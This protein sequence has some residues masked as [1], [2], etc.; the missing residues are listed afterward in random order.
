[1]CCGEERATV[2]IVAVG[3]VFPFTVSA[4]LKRRIAFGVETYNCPPVP[5]VPPPL[6]PLVPP[7]VRRGEITHPETMIAN[8]KTKLAEDRFI[9]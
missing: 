9:H 3:A 2:V 8:I 5:V 7:T 1:M 6:P 4:L